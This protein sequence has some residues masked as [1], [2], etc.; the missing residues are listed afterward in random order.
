MDDTPTLFTPVFLETPKNSLLGWVE[1]FRR[2]EIPVQG[3]TAQGLNEMAQDE[4]SVDMNDLAAL[5]NADPLMILRLLRQAGSLGS[6]SRNTADPK[7]VDS[8][9]TLILM[10][11]G[12]FFR[13]SV[14]LPQTQDWLATRPEALA[15][16]E[17]VLELGQRA[18]SFAHG[19]A[20]QLDDPKAP[21][22][23]EATL[24]HHF[25]EMLMWLHAPTLAARI[26]ALQ[27]ATPGLRTRQA[28]RSVLGIDVLELRLA[29]IKAWRLPDVLAQLTDDDHAHRAQVRCVMLGLRLARHT[30]EGWNH[31]GLEQDVQDIAELLHLGLEP[32]LR[33]LPKLELGAAAVPAFS[34]EGG[35]Q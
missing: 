4:D 10:G 7:T 16:L 34:S 18:A 27:A 14:G 22:I 26:D 9:E 5:I 25:V 20:A 15:G 11:T 24:L 6:K 23:H 2:V 13:A 17:R 29:L 35:Q 33:L 32:T 19:F 31:P 30:R 21:L 1:F 28:C 3:Q 12:P 8:L